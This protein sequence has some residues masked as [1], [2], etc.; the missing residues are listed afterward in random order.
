MMR[1]RNLLANILIFDRMPIAYEELPQHL[2]DALIAT[3]DVRFYDHSGVDYFSLGRVL[4]K[5]ILLQNES[6]GG[7]ST[8]S[9]QLAK[10]LFGRKNYGVLSMPVNKV[11]E[12][13]IARR[14]ERIY[15]KEEIITLYFNTV[16][17]SDNTY[18]IESASRKFFNINYEKIDLGTIRQHLLDP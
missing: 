3:E 15:S 13:I 17:F 10:N 14:M 5:S 9:I 16:P 18:G 11:K 12:A 1:R 2:I 8:V 7:G 6:S 4:V